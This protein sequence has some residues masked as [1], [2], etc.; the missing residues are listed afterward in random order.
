MWG[1][2]CGGAGEG[3]GMGVVEDHVGGNLTGWT[4]S[5]RTNVEGNPISY[6]PRRPRNEQDMDPYIETQSN[7]QVSGPKHV[8]LQCDSIRR[9]TERT[10]PRREDVLP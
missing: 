8:T 2:L 5:V 3:V 10:D 6:V 4:L 7:E 9:R 1:E